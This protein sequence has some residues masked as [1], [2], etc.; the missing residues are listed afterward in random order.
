MLSV[1][2]RIE[3]EDAYDD[4]MDV[5]SYALD[6][7]VD[8]RSTRDLR[9]GDRV[10]NDALDEQEQDEHANDAKCATTGLLSEV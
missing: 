2:E 4:W 8:A 6:D 9:L 3:S 1:R 5:G 7:A 10:G